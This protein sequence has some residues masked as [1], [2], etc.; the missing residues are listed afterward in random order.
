MFCICYGIMK[1]GGGGGG[2]TGVSNNIQI[3]NDIFY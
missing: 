1:G 2:E 3:Y